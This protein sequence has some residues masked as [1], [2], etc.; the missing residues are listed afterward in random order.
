MNVRLLK[1]AVDEAGAI[2]Y[3]LLCMDCESEVFEWIDS[4]PVLNPSME[5]IGSLGHYRCVH[6]GFRTCLEETQFL[7]EATDEKAAWFAHRRTK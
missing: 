1:A 2:V 4:I 6:C 7:M 5:Q 3:P